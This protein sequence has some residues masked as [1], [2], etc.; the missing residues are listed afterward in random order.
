MWLC[1]VVVTEAS[2]CVSVSV[3][4]LKTTYC[5][6]HEKTPSTVCI[7][8]NINWLSNIDLFKIVLLNNSEFVVGSKS[9]ILWWYL[10]PC[11]SYALPKPLCWG[12]TRKKV[13]FPLFSLTF[14]IIFELNT[15]NL[16]L[17][18]LLFLL[19]EYR[20]SSSGDSTTNSLRYWDLFKGRYLPTVIFL[21]SF[22]YF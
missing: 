9:W 10:C 3:V 22:H 12:W 6:H 15:N 19:V 1:C 14:R 16:L 8:W 18:S 11:T 17:L 2:F 13:T 5:L 4:T 7:I 20:A 21:I